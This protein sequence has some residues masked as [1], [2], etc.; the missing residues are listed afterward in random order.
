MKI[1]LGS[2]KPSWPSAISTSI[3]TSNIMATNTSASKSNATQNSADAAAGLWTIDRKRGVDDYKSDVEYKPPPKKFQPKQHNEIHETALLV[4][5]AT[6]ARLQKQPYKFSWESDSEGDD[7]SVDSYTA[8]EIKYGK[9]SS[10]VPT[11]QRENSKKEMINEIEEFIMDMTKFDAMR[12]DFDK[13]SE[14]V[15]ELGVLIM[16][17]LWIYV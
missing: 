17:F 3:K 8:E 14:P 7:G 2:F 1:Y 15:G 11:E 10:H 4:I 12:K 5:R 9:E 16:L 13:T 6:V